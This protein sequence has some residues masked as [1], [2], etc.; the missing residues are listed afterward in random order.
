MS[1]GPWL[2][3][4]FGFAGYC[5]GFFAQPS[6]VLTNVFSFLFVPAI[7]MMFVIADIFYFSEKKTKRC[8]YVLINET[9]NLLTL[10]I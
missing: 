8:S 5:S 2:N 3:P 4:P 9:P 7:L 1:G 10:K 6:P